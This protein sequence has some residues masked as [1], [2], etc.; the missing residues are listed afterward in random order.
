[1][2]VAARDLPS[3]RLGSSPLEG[4]LTKLLTIALAAIL[5]ALLY[6]ERGPIGTALGRTKAV[7]QSTTNDFTGGTAVGMGQQA[8]RQI[9]QSTLT[10]AIA[11]YRSL[12]GEEPRS[13]QGL[14]DEGCLQRANLVDEWGRPLEVSS[15]EH[16][17]VIRGLGADC[18]RGTADD[19]VLAR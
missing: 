10:S 18:K 8:K 19:W 2:A 3:R 12:R 4:T 7:V 16:G 9:L 5:A 6:A 14:V 17:L 15:N 1:M 13:L 11:A